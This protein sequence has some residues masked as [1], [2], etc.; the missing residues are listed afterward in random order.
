VGKSICTARLLLR[1]I[2]PGDTDTI[3][4]T[5][6]TADKDK[7]RSLTKSSENWWKVHGFGVWVVLDS[8]DSE[9]LGW[10]GLR[11]IPSASSPEILFGL[12]PHARGKG[13]ATESGQAA[14]E[15]AFGV[16]SV[17]SVWGA[18]IPENIAS[19]AVMERLGMLFESRTNLDGVDSVIY[20]AKKPAAKTI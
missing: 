1:P 11:P 18:T 8:R 10:C 16:R 19:I 12:A 9:V 2:A 7:V 14:L 13:F 20:R 17:N 5:S 15:Y 4:R 3:A 6:G